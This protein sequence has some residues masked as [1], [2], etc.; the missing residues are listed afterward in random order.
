MSNKKICQFPDS[1][2][3]VINTIIETCSETNQTFVVYEDEEAGTQSLWVPN[4]F[5]V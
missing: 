4:E 1:T 3:V 5:I 2:E